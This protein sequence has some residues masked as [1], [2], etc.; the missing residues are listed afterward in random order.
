M[1]TAEA[2]LLL[3]F[4]FSCGGGWEATREIQWQTTRGFGEY[5]ISLQIR[6]DADSVTV[7]QAIHTELILSAGGPVRAR[8]PDP[9]EIPL[10]R[11]ML[12]QAETASPEPL[13]GGGHQ[14]RLLLTMD[15]TLPGEASIGP[16]EVSYEI[17]EGE[18]W[19]RHTL[20][21][22]KLPVTILSLGVPTEGPI[23]FKP[24]RGIAWPQKSFL[25][26]IV[27]G[28]AILALVFGLSYWF[29]LRRV[30]RVAS[31]I[32]P[33]R[34]ALRELTDLERR[35]L[36]EKGELMRYYVELSTVVR[37]YVERAFKI[38]ALEQTTE[39][40][41]LSLT[42]FERFGHELQDDACGLLEEA[43]LVKFAKFDPGRQRAKDRLYAAKDFVRSSAPPEGE[44][45]DV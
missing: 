21:S 26:H 42:V 32:P 3:G 15:P 7:D 6:V 19:T 31:P 25:V 41:A 16:V 8:L 14:E 43:D 29:F 34:L 9:H 2:L 33:H 18:T 17:E 4:V 24:P 36:L 27:V 28:V 39:E 23:E 10:Q 45:D 12:R 22:D 38:P 35:G 37:R 40:F 30:R 11:L 13:T 1:K 5:P 44:A 20:K